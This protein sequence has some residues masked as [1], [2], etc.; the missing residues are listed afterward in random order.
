MY[1]IITNTGDYIELP[2]ART[3]AEA[4][5]ELNLRFTTAEIEEQEIELINT[6]DNED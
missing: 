6:E 3:R 1:Y 4:E 5:A 2:H